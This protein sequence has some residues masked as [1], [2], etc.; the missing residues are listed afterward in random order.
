MT[1]DF[2]HEEHRLRTFDSKWPHCYINPYLL[3]KTGLYYIGPH[4]QV[5]CFFCGVQISSWEMGDNE[6][7]E[8]KRWSPNC[9]LLMR[10]MTT[11]VPSPPVSELHKLLTRVNPSNFPDFE[12]ELNRLYSY[13]D[14]PISIKQTCQEMAEA[15]FFYTGKS[16]RVICFSCGGGLR[17]WCAEDIP[18]EQHALWYGQCEYLHKI[19]GSSYITSVHTKFANN[20]QT[21]GR[22][23]KRI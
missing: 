16:D 17:G 7:D 2:A 18:W 8:H 11:N 21:C 23:R 20:N 22:K 15:G 3:A 19:K 6:I 10:S 13:N 5:N 12:S 4:D 14:W 1:T 9:P